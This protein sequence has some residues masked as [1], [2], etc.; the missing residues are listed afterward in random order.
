[1]NSEKESPHQKDPDIQKLF[2]E[3]SPVSGK[4]WEEMIKSELEGQDYSKKLIWKTI[5]G[6]DVKPFYTADDLTHPVQPDVETSQLFSDNH[7]VNTASPWQVR[8]D[9]WLKDIKQINQAARE[10]Q[11]R[12]VD[13][14]GLSAST[15]KNY[16]DLGILLN[17]IDLERVSLH[18]LSSAS[19][20]KL[21]RCLSEYLKTKQLRLSQ[22]KGSINFDPVSYFTLHGEFYETF[23]K[24]LDELLA[25]I[26]FA[27][28]ENSPFSILNI[29]AHYYHNSG[30]NMVQELAFAL[31]H[32]VEYLSGAV[33]R[34]LDASELLKRMTF[35]FATGSNYFFE[36]AKFRAARILWNLISSQYKPE[37]EATRMFIHASG[38]I[39]N[40]TIY[41]PYVN[42]LRTTTETMSAAIAGVDSI[43]VLPFDLPYKNPDQF[44]RRIARNQQIIVRDEAYIGK[45]KDPSSGSYY[46]E[47]ITQSLVEN[48]WSLFLRIEDLGGFIKAFESGFIPGEIEKVRQLR[49]M[50]IAMRKDTLLG[51]NQYPN[52]QEKIL[53]KIEF[54]NFNKNYYLPD[55]KSYGPCLKPY[56]A[57]IPFEEIRLKVEQHE[58]SGHAVPKVFLITFG[59]LAMRKARATFITNF[60][61]CA[62]YQITDNAGFKTAGEATDAALLSGSNVFVL[63]SSDDEYG[64]LGLDIVQE[65]KSRKPDSIL[66]V[67]G[68]PAALTEPLKQAGVDDFIHIKTNIIDCLNTYNQ[69]LG[70]N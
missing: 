54:E 20:V 57:A 61:G 21:L 28:N 6:F 58:K 49:D 67:A 22:V 42:M 33:Q 64:T 63:C 59:N 39:W 27:K 1:M 15:V 44:S 68:N 53:E 23:E 66:V 50:N 31:S 60:F 4:E 18:F 26:D 52:S 16:E 56:R 48:A 10:Y 7:P 8:Q 25:I 47:S 17:G 30:A 12:G 35:S 43:N 11:N 37:D 46:I 24:N 69:K 62:G 14:I 3:F 32:A 55:D 34:G 19:Y 5:E 41:D 70:I 29:N 38:S 51:T 2:E 40:K 36:I 13:A 45:V 65:M 9:I